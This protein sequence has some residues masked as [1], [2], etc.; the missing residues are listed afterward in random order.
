MARKPDTSELTGLQ[1]EILQV[2]WDCREASVAQVQEALAERGRKLAYTT[3]MTLCRRLA[4]RGLLT[5][6]QRERAYI[7]SPAAKRSSVLKRLMGGL[8]DR[9]FG[10]SE[11]QLIMTVLADAKISPDELEALQ[12]LLAAKEQEIEKRG[13]SS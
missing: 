13:E 9:A 3:V 12:K 7:Y 10:G 1:L 2:L 11:A 4:D 5:Y 8:V 6:V